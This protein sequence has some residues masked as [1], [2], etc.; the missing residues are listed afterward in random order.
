MSFDRQK[1]NFDGPNFIYPLPCDN[2]L[3]TNAF[4]VSINH[5]PQF[6]WSSPGMNAPLSKTTMRLFPKDG[7]SYCECH[8]NSTNDVENESCVT[9]TKVIDG[10]MKNKRTTKRRRRMFWTRSLPKPGNDEDE[11]DVP[12][13]DG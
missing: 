12:R 10:I 6:H 13:S 1:P 2:T 3:N 4:D 9:D 5:H 8:K 11:D 7:T